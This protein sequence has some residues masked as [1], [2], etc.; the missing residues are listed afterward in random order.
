V[1]VGADPEWGEHVV[2]CDAGGLAASRAA[3]ERALAD[4]GASELSLEA[5]L[6]VSELVTNVVHH[7]SCDTAV[8]R[9]RVSDRAVRVEVEDSR[10]D[11]VATLLPRHPVYVNG[12]G[13]HI[14]AATAPRWGCDVHERGKVVWFELDRPLGGG[15]A[16]A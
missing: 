14:V 8:V 1:T 13:M 2:A 16:E 11:R 12:L 7:A 6:L 5:Q 10:R 9:V 3:V 15:P 4:A